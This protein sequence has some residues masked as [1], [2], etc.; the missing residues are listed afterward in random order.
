M[1]E[2]TQEILFLESQGSAWFTRNRSAFE[3][4]QWEDLP[5]S[6][7]QT[8]NIS[9]RVLLDI[10]CSGGW[11]I[12][13]LQAEYGCC[14]M[15]VEPSEEALIYAKQH[16]PLIKFQRGT[17]DNLTSIKNEFADCVLLWY[18]CHWIDRSSLLRSIAEVDRVLCD[19][20]YLLLG[21]FAPDAPTKV[22]YKHFRGLWTWKLAYHSIFLATGRY[23][24]VT[25]QTYNHDTGTIEHAP[26][27]QRGMIAL[28]QKGDFYANRG[29]LHQRCVGRDS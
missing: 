25:Y 11:R 28:L 10:G 3:R 5:L 24:L 21:D 13:K 12:G 7:L 27:E 29:Y 20:G 4:G 9:P 6:A 19:G 17:A 16:W 8:Y 15:G 22:P 23:S 14:A 1:T 18:V 2:K 26:S